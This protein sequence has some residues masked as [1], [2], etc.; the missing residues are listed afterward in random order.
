[1]K[2]ILDAIIFLMAAAAL[3]AIVFLEHTLHAISVYPK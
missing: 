2:Y 3:L 1:M